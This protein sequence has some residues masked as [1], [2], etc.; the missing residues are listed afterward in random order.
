MTL[1]D[2]RRFLISAGTLVASTA[3]SAAILRGARAA[4]KSGDNGVHY[5][6]A[7][8]L[9]AA[10][11]AREVSSAELVDLAIA[12][13]EARDGTLNAVVVRDFERAK[14]AAIEADKALARGEKR[15]LLG[16]PMTVK[17]SFNVAGLADHVGHSGRQG[18]S[19]ARRRPCSRSASRRLVPSCSARRTCRSSRR[20]SVAT[21][22]STARPTIRGTARTP[23]GSSGGAAAALAA[24]F[25]PLELGSDIGGSLRNPA[26]FC[27]VFAHK[28]SYGLLPRS[29]TNSA[30]RSGH[31]V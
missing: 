22:K 3:L 25:V 16:V 20:F 13:I 2:R 11:A 28:P 8:D 7:R 21:T 23:G 6:S 18:L 9:A 14:L 27:G 5:R 31:S 29:R 15:P 26:H 30:G 1:L 12:R 24:G 4:S 10:L 19:T 17:E